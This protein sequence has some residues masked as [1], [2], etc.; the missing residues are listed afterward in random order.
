MLVQNAFIDWHNDGRHFIV[1][2]HREDASLMDGRRV[3]L[4]ADD[5][6]NFQLRVGYPACLHNQSQSDWAPLYLKILPIESSTTKAFGQ[7]WIP[8]VIALLAIWGGFA[9]LIHARI[10]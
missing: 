1:D 8:L 3:G 5:A 10:I 7:H 2:G 4:N 9:F 6:G